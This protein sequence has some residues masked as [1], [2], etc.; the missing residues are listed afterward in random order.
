MTT[1]KLFEGT[2]R[3]YAQHRAAYP[4]ELIEQIVHEFDLDGTGR[5]LDLGCGT[6]LLTIPLAPHSDS[7][8]G[9]DP[10]ADMLAE[11]RRQARSAHIANVRWA[12]DGSEGL[13]R[14]KADL[15]RFRLVTFG[16]SFHWMDR[17]ATLESLNGMVDPDGGVAVID[18]GG[19]VWSGSEEWHRAATDVIRRWLGDQRRAGPGRT[20]A[21]P[22]ERHE[23]VIARSPFR[24]VR[25][26]SGHAERTLTLDEVVGGLYSTSFASKAL[27]GD[28]QPRFESD[29]R[30]T[31][32]SIVSD[33]K[34]H[35]RNSY[36]AIFGRL[37]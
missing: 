23:A 18:F 15:G 16:N 19:S 28:R 37:A 21:E 20:Y 31:L 12:L 9:L 17:E 4:D 7:A 29:L 3:F 22:D 34:F 27:L 11:A 25:V 35:E 32:T 30:S 2:A 13:E 6:G 33:G 36:S 24:R 26:V 8:A 10:D 1:P 5:L 14:R